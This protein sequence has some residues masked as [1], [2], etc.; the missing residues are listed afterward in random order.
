MLRVFQGGDSIMFHHSTTSPQTHREFFNQGVQLTEM[1]RYED[2]EKYFQKA[3]V[4]FPLDPDYWSALALLSRVKKAAFYSVDKYYW[5]RYI[6][7]GEAAKMGLLLDPERRYLA[8][9]V[10]ESEQYRGWG[11]YDS[12]VQYALSQLRNPHRNPLSV[13]NGRDDYCSVVEAYLTKAKYLFK[14]QNNHQAALQAIEDAKSYCR[15]SKTAQHVVERDAF[16]SLFGIDFLAGEIYEDSK[17]F[18][19]AKYALD[20]HINKLLC[21]YNNKCC[22]M[23]SAAY[24]MRGRVHYQLNRYHE[25]VVD[26]KQAIEYGTRNLEGQREARQSPMHIEVY[27]FLARQ[28]RAPSLYLEKQQY[29][30]AIQQAKAKEKEGLDAYLQGNISRAKPFFEA[31]LAQSPNL[32]F[33]KLGLGLCAIEQNDGP[34]A[35]K[36]LEESRNICSSDRLLRKIDPLIDLLKRHERELEVAKINRKNAISDSQWSKIAQNAVYSAINGYIPP[37]D[38]ISSTLSGIHVGGTINSEKQILLQELIV[39]RL[40]E[41]RLFR[42]GVSRRYIQYFTYKI[43]KELQKFLSHSSGIFHGRHHIH[44]SIKLNC[45]YT[46]QTLSNAIIEAINEAKT[47]CKEKKFHRSI[48][49]L[50]NIQSQG[51]LQEKVNEIKLNLLQEALVQP[52]DDALPEPEYPCPEFEGYDLLPSKVSFSSDCIQ[53]IMSYIEQGFQ[54]DRQHAQVAAQKQ[55]ANAADYRRHEQAMADQSRRYA[56][57]IKQHWA[58]AMPFTRKQLFKVAKATHHFDSLTDYFDGLMDC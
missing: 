42:D 50:E 11:V 26:F 56:Q 31:S 20:S 40:R 27:L 2:A 1:G 7:C 38:G 57:Q 4:L 13:Q 46:D 6:G 34:A 36:Y 28:R 14:S 29:F 12:D 8:Q 10:L 22:Y 16:S 51:A 24:E 18:D 25:A 52:L 45:I 32:P 37:A 21:N 35:I 5:T 44:T 48:A 3:L 49:E 23:L 55:A 30:K 47:W 53:R 9:W 43:A 19:K 17:Q 41:A 15:K 54:I 39:T 58:N 33:S